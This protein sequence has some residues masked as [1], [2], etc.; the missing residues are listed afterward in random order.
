MTERVQERAQESESNQALSQRVHRRVERTR[1]A[2]QAHPWRFAVVSGCVCLFAAIVWWSNAAGA[3]A[4]H[5]VANRGTPGSTVSMASA[6]SVSSGSQHQAASGSALGSATSATSATTQFASTATSGQKS[7][8][9]N[10]SSAQSRQVIEQADVALSLTNVK[11]T[12]NQLS[13]IADRAGGFVESMNWSDTAQYS[14]V[15]MTIRIPEAAFS[16]FVNHA[17]SLGKVSSFSQT[18]Q[19]VTNQVNGLQ[20][21]IEELTAQAQAYTRLY[22]KA[23]SMKDML[24]IQQSLSSVNN[25]IANFQ[26]ELHNLNRQVQL[27]TVHVQLNATAPEVVAKPSSPS[28]TEA[29]NRSVQALVKSLHGL[30]IFLAWLLPWTVLV[31]I[32]VAVW[33][34]VTRRK[35]AKP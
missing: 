24:Q 22:N 27:A 31:F 2:I 21:N 25:Q 7:A 8:A 18:G 32:G 17:K 6:Q 26:G 10:V 30:V 4:I 15:Q 33:R 11:T 35:H 14:N 19:D 34:F 3:H 20:Q 28:V 23:Q 29:L 5:A 12:A 13:S 1:R 9:G 16:S